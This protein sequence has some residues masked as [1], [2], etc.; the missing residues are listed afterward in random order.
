[1]QTH[2]IE[3]LTATLKAD[4]TIAESER[5]KIL[6]LV[7]GEPTPAPEGNGNSRTRIYSRAECAKLLGDKTP[8]FIDLLCRKGLLQKFTARGSQRSIG[9]TSES[10]EKFLEGGN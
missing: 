2:T 5:R 1:V 10:L 6:K 3:I 8:R 4:N 7:R 9:V